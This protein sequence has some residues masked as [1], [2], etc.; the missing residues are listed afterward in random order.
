MLSYSAQ[1]VLTAA[2]K[3]TVE[4]G[5]FLYPTGRIQS[6]IAGTTACI[7]VLVAFG[8]GRLMDTYGVSAPMTVQ[9]SIQVAGLFGIILPSA[10]RAWAVERE[11]SASPEALC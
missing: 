4:R 2:Y 9:M 5:G 6:K 11:R 7:Q 1:G 10:L 3:E 8:S